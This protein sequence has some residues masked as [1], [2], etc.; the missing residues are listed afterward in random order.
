MIKLSGTAEVEFETL[1]PTE[2]R[3]RPVKVMNL[4]M[5]LDAHG[6]IYELNTL[7]YS[8]A[9]VIDGGEFEFS[10]DGPRLMLKLRGPVKL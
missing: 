10:D 3:K 2:R 6:P 5:L 4:F 1:P 9:L 7:R 8:D